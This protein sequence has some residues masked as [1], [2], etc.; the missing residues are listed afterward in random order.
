MATT[1][2]KIKNLLDGLGKRFFANDARD[3]LM[4]PCGCAGKTIHVILS[5][6]N[7]G[8][9]LQLLSKDFNATPKDGAS[10]VALFEE[11]LALN[12][13]TKFIKL[14]RDPQDG[15]VVGYGDSWIEDGGLTA[16]QLDRM[17]GTFVSGMAEAQERLEVAALTGKSTRDRE[18]DDF[19]SSCVA[20]NAESETDASNQDLNAKST[21]AP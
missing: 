10:S 14:G 11:M 21:D 4:I 5:L 18:F 17:V 19:L 13:E 7:E 9:F 1:L 12:F 20:E 16:G 3:M 15:E 2:A 8:R 6:Q